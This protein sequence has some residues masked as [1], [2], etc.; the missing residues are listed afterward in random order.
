MIIFRYLHAV[1]DVFCRYHTF[2]Q[3][4]SLKALVTYD[5]FL[6]LPLEISEIWS[7]TFT[8]TKALFFL[9]RYSYLIYQAVIQ[10]FYFLRTDTMV[11]Q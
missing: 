1:S 4:E 11:C 7:G 5:Y 8:A 3:H 6:T 10:S 9:N 2:E